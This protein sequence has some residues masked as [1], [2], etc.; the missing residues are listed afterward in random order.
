LIGDAGEDT[1]PGKALQFLQE[2]LIQDSN[3]MVLFLGDNVYPEGLILDSTHKGIISQ[4]KLL[5][6]INILKDYKGE[7]F[8]V[9][10]NHDWASGKMSGRKRI[11]DEAAF[12]NRTTFSFN[13]KKHGNSFSIMQPALHGTPG[14]A[15]LKYN[16][17]KLNLIFLDT[18]WFLHQ[19]LFKKVSKYPGLSYNESKEKCFHDLDSMLIN[20]Q[21]NNEKVIIAA[22]HPLITNGRHSKKRRVLR[23]LNNY[24]PLQLFGLM[25]ANRFFVQDIY[26]PAYNKMRKRFLNIITKYD[27]II[28]VCGHDHD[29]E[30]IKHENFN[31][32]ISGAGSKIANFNHKQSF[33]AQF[34]NDKETGF[35]KLIINNINEIE[36]QAW[37]AY[38]KKLLYNRCL[39]FLI[40]RRC[41]GCS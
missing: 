39:K 27:N 13:L 5:S 2:K 40:C 36:I 11:K 32:I 34:Q 24:S 37:G 30:F 19:K 23:F 7:T 26:Q 18:Q 35:F 22:H 38:S 1:I 3:S 8:F 10:G 12:I 17:I 20:A 25:G 41:R 16:D 29:L 31:E 33:P 9:P 4:K 15:L 6:Q 14:P 28:Y 21:L